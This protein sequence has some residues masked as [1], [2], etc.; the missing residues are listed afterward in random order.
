[1]ARETGE[2]DDADG[3]ESWWGECWSRSEAAS[4]NMESCLGRSVAYV[5]ARP[6][7]RAD[8]LQGP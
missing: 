2:G 3:G 5:R 1:M 8:D 7:I 6:V 4:G